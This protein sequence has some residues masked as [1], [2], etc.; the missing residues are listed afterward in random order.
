VH[1]LRPTAL[2]AINVEPSTQT[3]RVHTS[4]VALTFE[5]LTLVK[6][7]PICQGP[8]L[9]TL[10]QAVSSVCE[11]HLSLPRTNSRKYGAQILE[12]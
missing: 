8:P 9:H 4:R 1:T 11:T 10:E 12:L 5:T 2:T 3:H 6:E 7:E